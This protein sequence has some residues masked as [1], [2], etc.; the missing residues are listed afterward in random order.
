MKAGVEL[1]QCLKPLASSIRAG[2]RDALDAIFVTTKTYHL[3]KAAEELAEHGEVLRPKQ[4]TVGCHNGH[5][6]GIDRTFKDAIGGIFCKALVPG[7]YTFKEDGSGFEVTNAGQ[8]W[9][10][11]SRE[12]EVKHLAEQ[13]AR[14][15]VATVAGGFEADTRKYL[16]NNTANLV[17]VIANTNCHGLVSDPALRARMHAIFTETAMVLQASPI[18]APHF[19]DIEL[20]ELEDQVITG[21]AS[22]GQHYPSSCKDFRAG[23]EIEVESLNGYIVALGKQLGIPTPVNEAVVADVNIVLSQGPVA[24]QGKPLAPPQTRTIVRTPLRPGH[25]ISPPAMQT[26]TTAAAAARRR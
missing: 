21:I 18:H 20:S 17:S 25:M 5:V 9:A 3:P 6:L 1:T 2:D 7:G 16:V 15:S 4:A 13:M 8:K 12:A 24:E 23:R 19:P 26:G 10:L 22:Y 11:L 14:R